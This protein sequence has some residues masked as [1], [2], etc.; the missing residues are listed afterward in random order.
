[1]TILDE[2]ECSNQ[3]TTYQKSRNMPMRKSSRIVRKPKYYN[4]E[5][6]DD[7][8]DDE[9]I[10]SSDRSGDEWNLS[11]SDDENSRKR[12]KTT[13]CN[14]SSPSNANTSISENSPQRQFTTGQKSR[15]FKGNSRRSSPNNQV[16]ET[17]LLRRERNN[18]S[19][20]KSRARVREATKAAE[21]CIDELTKEKDQL[22]KD[23]EILDKEISLLKSL[24]FHTFSPKGNLVVPKNEN[25]PQNEHSYSSQPIEGTNDTKVID[26]SHLK[27]FKQ[28]NS[29]LNVEN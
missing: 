7:E 14:S 20:R 4:D 24:I 1:M 6:K 12:V 26:L 28:M 3:D 16:D 15:N 2:A 29:C 22:A 19:V 5:V 9:M 10:T 25:S 8:I 18:I 21:K 11:D 13:R 27:F 23:Q 17:Y